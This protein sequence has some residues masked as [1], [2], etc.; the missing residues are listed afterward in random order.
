MN[1]TETELA[2]VIARVAHGAIGQKRADHVTPYFTHP[3]RV[4]ELTRIW[5]AGLPYADQAVAA[6]YLHDVLEDTKL[7]RDDLIQAGISND[8]VGIVERLTKDASAPASSE[9]YR[10][11]AE[12]EVALL[13]KCADRCANLEDALREV[14]SNRELTRWATYAQKTR[15]DLLP[16]YASMPKLQ[17]HLEDRL[18]LIEE[19]LTPQ[20]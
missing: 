11:I 6:A 15:T 18:R 4:A 20:P 17:E 10:G 12:S 8:V 1:Q 3:V 16:M 19:A 14:L 2:R 5:C 7:A 13:V 9:Y